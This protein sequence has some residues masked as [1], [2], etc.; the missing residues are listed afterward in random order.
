MNIFRRVKCNSILYLHEPKV[1]VLPLINHGMEEYSIIVPICETI[2]LGRL[3]N[4]GLFSFLLLVE[5]TF[6][7]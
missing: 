7:K 5:F 3:G 6:C 4:P 2:F 1:G